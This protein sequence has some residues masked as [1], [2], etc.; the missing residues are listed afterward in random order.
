[1]AQVVKPNL[2]EGEF[3][4]PVPI[5][6]HESLLIRPGPPGPIDHTPHAGRSTPRRDLS[7]PQQP[8]PGNAAPRGRTITRRPSSSAAKDAVGH[9]G[10]TRSRGRPNAGFPQA[11]GDS[12]TR[13]A[14][15]LGGS[16]VGAAAFPQVLTRFLD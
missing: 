12:R 1:M 3:P 11:G 15:L 10:A 6:T 16:S 9:C 2:L 8:K 7:R 13:N 14:E 5:T 4:E